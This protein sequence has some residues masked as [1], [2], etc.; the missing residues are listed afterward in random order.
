MRAEIRVSMVEVM[1]IPSV[2]FTPPLYQ[3]RATERMS[4]GMRCAEFAVDSVRRT[5]PWK[6]VKWRQDFV[7]REVRLGPARTDE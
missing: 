6:P 3:V 5:E 7:P 1:L 2:K 4:V